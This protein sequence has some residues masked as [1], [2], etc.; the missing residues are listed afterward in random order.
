MIFCAVCFGDPSSPL[1]HGYNYAVFTM[2]AVVAAVLFGFGM[3]FLNFR[4]RA[5]SSLNK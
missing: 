2:L 4:K 1:T 3:L 5:G